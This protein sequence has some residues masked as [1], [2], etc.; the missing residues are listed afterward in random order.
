MVSVRFMFSKLKAAWSR[1][2]GRAFGGGEEAPAPAVEYKG[3]RIRATPYRNTDS[4]API[5]TR[6]GKMR[7]RLRSRKRSRSSTCRA[8]A[9]SQKPMLADGGAGHRAEKRSTGLNGRKA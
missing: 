4:S 7:L 5:R 1:L 3:Y 6:G 8:T 2:A 9:S